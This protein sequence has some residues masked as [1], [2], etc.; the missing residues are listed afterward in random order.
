M[1][2]AAHSRR[3]PLMRTSSGGSQMSWR[4]GRRLL[5]HRTGSLRFRAEPG[6]PGL[7]RRCTGF[8]EC[9]RGR[10][11][12]LVLGGAVNPE[13][14]DRRCEPRR[15][16]RLDVG[17][18][19]RPRGLRNG[20]ESGRAAAAV[21]IAGCLGRY[22]EGTQ[23]SPRCRRRRRRIRPRLP[24]SPA[25]AGGSLGPR[26]EASGGA[27]AARRD[28]G[29]RCGFRPDAVADVRRGIALLKEG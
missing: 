24:R 21:G 6:P 26:W 1:P 8:L 23:Q 10:G 14:A 7:Q 4:P 29:L 5:R 9:L 12:W 28:R 2:T 3:T 20:C 18:S 27:P 16:A 13:G 17:G 22:R 11:I 25:D 19:V 15:C